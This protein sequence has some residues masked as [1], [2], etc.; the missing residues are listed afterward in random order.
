MHIWNDKYYILRSIN[1]IISINEFNNLTDDQ[2]H[3]VR[4]GIYAYAGLYFKSEYY[5]DFSWYTGDVAI[6]EIYEKLIYYQVKNISR[7]VSIEKQRL[8]MNC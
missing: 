5:N 4:N 1:E 7:I 2:L 6:E 3:N 8:L